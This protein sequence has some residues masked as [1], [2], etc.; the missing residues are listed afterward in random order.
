MPRPAPVAR[1][2]PTCGRAFAR[3]E[4][5]TICPLAPAV[6]AWLAQNLPDPAAPARIVSV[7]Q[8]ERLA[9]PIGTTVLLAQYGSWRGVATA[10]GLRC[11]ARERGTPPP[12]L[13]PE[14]IADLQRMAQELHGGVFG[15]SSSEY[16]MH[17]QPGAMMTHGL[18]HRHGTWAAVLALAGLRV[19]TMSEYQRASNARRRAQQVPQNARRSLDRGDEPISREY[20][21]IPVM[22]KPRQLP[23][24]G[25]AWTVR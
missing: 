19:G 3:L 2:C 10:F 22:P 8:Y 5:H 4:L 23:S 21:G 18:K 14:V 25:V 12:P 6:Q 24:G 7:E 16:D 15:P 13:E 20:T 9:P 17:R 1:A 11:R